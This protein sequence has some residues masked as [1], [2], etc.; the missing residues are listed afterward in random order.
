MIFTIESAIADELKKPADDFRIKDLFDARTFNTTRVEVARAGQT[1]AYEKSKSPAK[2]TEPPK[3]VWKQVA[4]ASKD[5]E[6]AKVDALLTALTNAR[7]TS[8][9]DKSTQT[10]LDTP[11]LAVTLKY[12]GRR[13]TGT[14]HVRPQRVGRVRTT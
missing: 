4:P 14:R 6:A 8:F 3:D 9:V 11:E 1:T 12:R 2:G 7:A 13:K 5:V 10:G